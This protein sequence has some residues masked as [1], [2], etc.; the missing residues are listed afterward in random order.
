MA[1]V[2]SV[3]QRIAAY[4]RDEV[5]ALRPRVKSLRDRASDQPPPRGFARALRNGPHRPA[6]VPTLVAEVK[7][8]SPSKGVIRQ[9][10]DPAA[11]ARSYTAGG[12]SA[13]SCLTDGPGFGGSLEALD[14]VRA[15]TP[16]PVLRKDFFIDPLQVVEARAH[17]ADAVLVILAMLDDARARELMD[18]AREHGMDALVETHTEDEARRAAALGAT[19]V[20]VNNR[21]LH[22]FEVSLATFARVAAHLP[23]GATLVAESGIHT[24]ADAQAMRDAGAHAMLV[25]ESL[26]RE[27]DVERAVRALVG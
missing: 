21:D 27:G 18:A 3:L 20:G 9:D 12:A 15:A 1:D 24:R 11:I 23:E 6:D 2:P 19:L 13:I 4:K 5:A 7:K 10:F 8:A 16:L 17:G 26:M 14:A 25:G 22:T